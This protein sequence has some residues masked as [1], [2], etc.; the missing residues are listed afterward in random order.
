MGIRHKE[1]IMIMYKF[2]VFSGLNSLDP[3][4]FR[5]T[6]RKRNIGVWGQWM[7]AWKPQSIS[8][9]AIVLEDDM[10]VSP[11]F[12]LYVK[13]ALG[14]YSGKSVRSSVEGPD[15]VEFDMHTAHLDLL[16]AVRMDNYLSR[17]G[18]RIESVKWNTTSDE[19][20]FIRDESLIFSYGGTFVRNFDVNLSPL[21]IFAKKYAGLP[22]INSIALNAQ[23]LDPLRPGRPLGVKNARSPYLY[24]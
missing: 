9:V 7:L 15:N 22:V 12:Y 4:C 16:N 19:D 17:N 2:I 21:E 11:L 23:Y 18:G 5:I 20:K 14:R 24:R 13:A 1:V 3:I 6:V 8:E 10:E